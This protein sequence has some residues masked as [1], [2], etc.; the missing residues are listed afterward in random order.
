VWSYISA[1]S[2]AFKSWCWIKYRDSFAF[3]TLRE[4]GS[5]AL[6]RFGSGSERKGTG[7]P[8]LSLPRTTSLR[9]KDVFA[10]G[11]FS[12][13]TLGHFKINYCGTVCSVLGCFDS[14]CDF[15]DGN[16]NTQ[17]GPTEIQGGMP[18]IEPRTPSA[19]SLR[20]CYYH[21]GIGESIIVIIT[22]VKRIV[23]W[24]EVT[25]DKVQF[26]VPCADLRHAAGMLRLQWYEVEAVLMYR[27]KILSANFLPPKYFVCKKCSRYWCFSTRGPWIV[28]NIIMPSLLCCFCNFKIAYSVQHC[29]NIVHEFQTEIDIIPEVTKRVLPLFYIT[30][31]FRCNLKWQRDICVYTF[32]RRWTQ[33]SD[34]EGDAA[35]SC[36]P[37]NGAQ[38]RSVWTTREPTAGAWR[39]RSTYL[40][41]GPVR[42]QDFSFS[43]LHILQKTGI[44]CYPIGTVTKT[45][46][47]EM[48]YCHIL[49]IKCCHNT[50]CCSVIQF[51]Q[52]KFSISISLLNNLWYKIW[53]ADSGEDS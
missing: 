9:F 37:S 46:F 41:I 3:Y 32:A 8:C 2:Y 51:S 19:E 26:V 1:P 53:S 43:F 44:R 48:I 35:A 12:G 7:G 13:L 15:Q 22:G 25:K 52:C 18:G 40:R 24:V 42:E 10:R 36:G 28:V 6:I 38:D 4:G 21:L 17:W 34:Q 27:G 33:C 30:N 16:S 20:R 45:L 5:L 49:R 11:I 29:T 50:Y 39:T 47:L 31:N 14:R 23:N